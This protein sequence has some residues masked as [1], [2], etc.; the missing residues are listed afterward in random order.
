MDTLLGI[1][2]IV[3][4]YLGIAAIGAF[5]SWIGKIWSQHRSKIR[6]EVLIDVEKKIDIQKEIE[7]FKD[8]LKYIEHKG[9][10]SY[11]NRYLDDYSKQMNVKLIGEFGNFLGECPSCKKG[12]LVGRIGR[13][14]KFIGCTEY[15]SCKFTE[16]VKEAKIKYKEAI[17]SEILNDIQK[18]YS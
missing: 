15:P 6:D 16:D 5:F 1:L 3:G 4:F 10:Y 9:E 17:G 2:I 7:K 13:Y 12:R 11:I 14:G 18:A 8:K